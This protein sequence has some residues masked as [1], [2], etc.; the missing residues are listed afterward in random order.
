[1]KQLVV[2]LNN[3][4][5][6]AALEAE[7]A[8]RQQPLDRVIAEAL[9]DWLESLADADLLPSLEAAHTEWERTGG[10]EAEAFF[11]QLREEPDA[12]GAS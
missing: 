11:R 3:D 10:V 2:A 1:M 5:L 8:R 7:A 12:P 6:Y 9:E 4:E